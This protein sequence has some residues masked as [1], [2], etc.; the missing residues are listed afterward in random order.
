MTDENKNKHGIITPQFRKSVTD[1]NNGIFL[2][3]R[4]SVPFIMSGSDSLSNGGLQ[5]VYDTTNIGKDYKRLINPLDQR[6]NRIYNNYYK[7]DG[8][9]N[10]LLAQMIYA[11]DV[12]NYDESVM[13]RNR[14]HGV[15]FIHNG[16]ITFSTNDRYV[17]VIDQV[18]I[19]DM[20]D[21][22]PQSLNY[23]FNYVRKI[24][25]ALPITTFGDMHDDGYISDFFITFNVVDN[26]FF[27]KVGNNDLPPETVTH[28][29][30]QNFERQVREIGGLASP[31]LI[32][33]LSEVV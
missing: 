27:V 24:G 29:P 8:R 30:Y 16:K 4:L 17:K 28:A 25:V 7:R 15:M 9:I 26:R 22:R 12:Q 1:I 2:S 13:R 3:R 32:V 31:C 14:T 23:R 18:F 21:T 5:L 20:F 6:D 33:D 10:V 11:N 19:S